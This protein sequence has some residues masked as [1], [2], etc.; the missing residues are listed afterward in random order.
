MLET[1]GKFSKSRKTKH[2]KSNFFFIKDKVDS[3]EV[4]NVDCPAGVMW[5]DALTKPL[6]GTDFIKKR[7][8]LVNCAMEYKDEEESTTKKRRTLIDQT[9]QQDTI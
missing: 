4:K 5:S 6:Q 8:Q 2:I 7:A 1:N 3:Q 9:S